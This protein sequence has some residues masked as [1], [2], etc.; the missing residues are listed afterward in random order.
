RMRDEVGQGMVAYRGATGEVLWENDLKYQGPCLLLADT[1]ITQAPGFALDIHTGARKM[2]RHP[3]SGE[4][5]AWGYRRKYGCNSAIGSRRLLTFRSAAAG[6]YDL[7]G[8][9]GTGNLGGFRSGCTS[10]LIPAGGIL[11]APD[12]SRT[13]TCAYQNQASLALVHAPD[14]EMWTFNHFPHDGRPVRRVGINFGAPGDRRDADGTLWLDYP[15]VGGESPDIPVEIVRDPDGAAGSGD[16][17]DA[18][19]KKLRTVRYHASAIEAADL[20]WVG[21][22]AVELSGEVALKL[23][24]PHRVE[25]TNEFPDGLPL[26][27]ANAT[28]STRVPADRVPQSGRL[29]RTSLSKGTAESDLQAV[30]KGYA[31]LGSPSLTVEF[32]VSTGHDIDYVDARYVG[33][34]KKSQGFVIDNRALRVRYFVADA[35]RKKSAPEAR[36]ESD[37]K[38]PADRW[39]HVA[40]T[41]DA[42][43]GTAKLYRDGEL[44]DSHD[45]PDDRPLWW[46]TRTPGLVIGRG[47]GESTYLDELRISRGALEPIQFL[48]STELPAED[49]SV[50]GYWRMESAKGATQS[51]TGRVYTVRLVFAELED[52]LVG[53][54]VFDVRIQGRRR[55]RD[56]DIVRE[57]GGPRRLVI[58]EFDN[59]AVEDFLRIELQPRSEKKPLLGGVQVVA[60]SKSF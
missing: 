60:K 18:D 56:F 27:A 24:S 58:K 34:D 57:A 13:C 44:L 41:Y 47:A 39:V 15:S 3:L 45:G 9:G 17:K 22:S 50:I 8:D 43:S 33:K 6:Y 11:C 59:I 55:L 7:A 49:E 30:V 20:D 1:V 32:W 52:V 12:Y 36:L 2:R 37:E 10:N 21:A 42:P 28:V 48:R 26:S 51:R 16:G 4:P 23:I 25:V 5:V 54:R 29:N 35:E 40:F 31:P 53:E 14:A 19:G 38:I 46:D